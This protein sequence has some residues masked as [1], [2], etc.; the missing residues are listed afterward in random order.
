[1]LFEPIAIIAELKILTF[2]K[3]ARRAFGVSLYDKI[4]PNRTGS[5][6]R[7][8]FVH[9]LYERLSSPLAARLICHLSQL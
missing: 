1:M 4:L 9:V 3:F 6:S 5:A 8:Y 2:L 7:I